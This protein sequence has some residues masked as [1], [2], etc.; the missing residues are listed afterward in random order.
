[1]SMHNSTSKHASLRV[2]AY[3]HTY[4]HSYFKLQAPCNKPRLTSTDGRRDLSA[5]PAV[6]EVTSQAS[7]MT[8]VAVFTASL[9]TG[10][11]TV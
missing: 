8:G 5:G 1:M 10:A 3:T 7:L 9:M 11:A 6:L 2:H 4:T